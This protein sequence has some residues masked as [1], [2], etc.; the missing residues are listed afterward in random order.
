MIHLDTKSLTIMA[1]R[2][3]RHS[4]IYFPAIPFLAHDLNVSIE[5]NFSVTAYLIA[6]GV[7]PSINGSAAGR[8]GRRPVFIA[9][10]AMYV[11]VNVGLALQRSLAALISLRMLQS[12]A[13]SGSFAFA[14][15]VLGINLNT[16]PSVAPM[17]SGLLLIKWNWSSIFWFLSIFSCAVLLAVLFLLP[18]TCRAIVGN[19]S[20]RPPRIVNRAILPILRPPWSEVVTTTGLASPDSSKDKTRKPKATANPLTGLSLLKHHG[21]LLSIICYAIYYTVYSCL[22]AS[23]ST[24]F[25]EKY[26]VTGL[27]SG[28]IYIPFGV[29]C[30]IACSLTDKLLDHDYRRTAKALGVTVDQRRGDDLAEF[31][32]EY[33][34][35][36]TCKWI[37]AV[38]GPLIVGYGWALQGRA[39]MAVPLVLQFLIGFTNQVNFT[40]LNALLVDYHS[41][42]S[43]T[44][45]AVNNLFRCELAAGELAMLDVILRKLGPG[46]TFVIF[47]ALHMA[48]LPGLWVLE[49]YG[50]GWR[51]AEREKKK[52]E[53][54]EQG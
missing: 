45:Q 19:G 41:D 27:V 22:Q 15:G 12:A 53:E 30:V 23:L 47:A 33:A 44:I 39:S 6:S 40:S 48:T 14:Y 51:K 7:F 32:I 54:K 50:L 46:R 3:C 21:T 25:V 13:I 52:N 42:Q 5:I 26:H 43:S 20:T 9:T 36:R 28:L 18:E 4:F 35:L 38:C 10:L 2:S 24:I 17:I 37:T 8:Y 16:P 34:R 11:A 49:R 29:S 31:P 1:R